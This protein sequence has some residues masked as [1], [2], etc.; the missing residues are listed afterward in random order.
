MVKRKRMKR[1]PKPLSVIDDF[2]KALD[3]NIKSAV[4]RAGFKVKKKK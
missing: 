2:S 1:L 3:T 4:K